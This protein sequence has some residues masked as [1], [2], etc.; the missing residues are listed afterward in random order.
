M[1]CFVITLTLALA[2]LAFVGCSQGDADKQK[3]D[4]TKG[5][6]GGAG[7]SVKPSTP[8]DEEAD[9]K[10]AMEKLPN[11]DRKLAEAQK[12]CPVLKDSPLGS[13]GVPIKVTIQGQPV[14]LCCDGCEKGALAN[15]KKTLDEVAR[16]KAKNK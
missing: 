12:I 11:A 15:P 3:M 1:K 13:M 2:C 4:D 6:D 7:N 8:N 14:F 16:L 5:K 9:I 10:A